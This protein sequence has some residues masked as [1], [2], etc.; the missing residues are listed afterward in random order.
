MA[1]SLLALLAAVPLLAA[2]EWPRIL[3]IS[4]MA[5]KVSDIERSVPFYRDFLGFAEQCRLNNLKDGSLLLVCFKVSDE[6]SIEVFTGLLPGEERL[7]QL[8][9]RVD[10]AEAMRAHLAK[11]G[12]QVPENV[13]KGQMKNL[14][15]T[16]RDPSG[17]NIEFVQYTLDGW[18]RRDRGKFLPDA[19]ISEHITHGGVVVT[20]VTAALHFYGD[21][22]GFTESWRG[23]ASSEALS[24][25]NMKVP[26]SSDYVEFMLD[27]K[28][29]PHFCLLVPDMEKAKA[30]LERNSYR[31]KYDK[32]L[33]VR[34]GKNRKRQLNLYDPDGTRVELMEPNTVDGVPVPSSA[35]PLP[36]P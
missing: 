10:D 14:G 18:T 32:P 36:V 30:K 17:Y 27:P 33:E 2:Q 7:H 24:W 35:A 31:S 23:G 22:L 11:N 8:A 3:G 34:V 21:I 1:L 12:F 13:G 25:I 5:V 9:Y 15:F 6:Q 29:T 26:A 19:R 16:V 28:A 4:H 20:D